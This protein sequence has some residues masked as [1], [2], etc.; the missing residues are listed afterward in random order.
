MFETG[1]AGALNGGVAARLGASSMWTLTFAIRLAILLSEATSNTAA[2][3]M[4]IPVAIPI[5]QAVGVKNSVPPA[6][7]TVCI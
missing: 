6:N 2:A 1:V 4:V 7:A 5:S 3:N